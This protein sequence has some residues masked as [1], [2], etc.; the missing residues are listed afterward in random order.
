MRGKWDRGEKRI[1]APLRTDPRVGGERTVNVGAAG[2]GSVNRSGP[3][4]SS[5]IASLLE[6][7]LHTGRTHQIRVH[8]A[9]AGHAVAGDQKYGDAAF[10]ERC[11]PW[12]CRAC[13]CTRAV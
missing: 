13:S 12:D 3:C 8:A 11:G 1:D 5:A 7:T 6:V 10:N 9:H 4:S 2:K